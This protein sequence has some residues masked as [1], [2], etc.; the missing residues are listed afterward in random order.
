MG[1]DEVGTL[2]GPTE[3]RAI[4]DRLIGDHGGP[5]SEHDGRQCPCGVR[6]RGGRGAVHGRWV[7]R[8]RP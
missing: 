1:A 4:L 5:H 6:K 2:K 7:G 3:R 8:F